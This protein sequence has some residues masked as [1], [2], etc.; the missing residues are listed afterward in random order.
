MEKNK[1][2]I[3]KLLFELLLENWG[4]SLFMFSFLIVLCTIGTTQPFKAAGYLLVLLSA[5]AVLMIGNIYKGYLGSVSF[6]LK[7]ERWYHRRPII[8]LL[9]LIGTILLCVSLFLYTQKIFENTRFVL[10]II[11]GLLYIISAILVLSIKIEA[12]FKNNKIE[13]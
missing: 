13:S 2:L 11:V 5:L 10:F 1:K 9:N 8:I 4:V 3:L 7:K 6:I 12:A